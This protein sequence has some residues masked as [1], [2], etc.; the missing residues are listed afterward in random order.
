MLVRLPSS[1]APRR[2]RGAS[3]GAALLYRSFQAEHRP[4]YKPH[5]PSRTS[6]A[7]KL[8][9]AAGFAVCG[10]AAWGAKYVVESSAQAAREERFASETTLA[11]SLLDAEVAAEGEAAEEE[12]ATPQISRTHPML[13]SATGLD[14]NQKLQVALCRRQSWLRASQLGPGLGMLG[15]L[16]VVI[17][18]NTGL[19]RFP[20]GTRMAAPLV[21]CVMG[22]SVG[23]Y[24]GGRELK[25][26]MNQALQE[27]AIAGVH[28]RGAERTE[29]VERSIA[30]AP[31]TPA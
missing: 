16:A 8:G 21:G 4:A 12:I 3:R 31:R 9:F 29:R 5:L 17:V 14:D 15:Y 18:E 22:M 2:L 23:A 30:G 24:V 7:H 1:L 28:L 20:R 13:L 11:P 25:P 10:F 6:T 26:Q 27:K 19:G